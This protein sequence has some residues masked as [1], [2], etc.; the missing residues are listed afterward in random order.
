[1]TGVRVCVSMAPSTRYWHLETVIIIIFRVW[2]ALV[3]CVFCTWFVCVCACLCV[4][5]LFVSPF[6]VIDN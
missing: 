3:G 5:V 4:F 6:V 1:V 2:A